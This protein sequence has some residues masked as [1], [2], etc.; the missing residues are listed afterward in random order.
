[1]C[2]INDM[3]QPS[4]FTVTKAVDNLLSLSFPASGFYGFALK[5]PS[6]LFIYLF[7]I[8]YLFN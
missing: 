3:F 8:I 5:V 1:M 2:I 7:I 4:P 6:N